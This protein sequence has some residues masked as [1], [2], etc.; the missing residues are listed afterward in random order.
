M[1]TFV[2]TTFPAVACSTCCLL[3]L[4]LATTAALQLPLNELPQH[5]PIFALE[6]HIVQKTL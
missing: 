5:L 3:H 4:L 1:N 6:Q 2:W